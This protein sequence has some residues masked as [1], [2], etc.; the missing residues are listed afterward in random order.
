MRITAERRGD[1]AYIASEALVRHFRDDGVGSRFFAN[2][3]DH[4]GLHSLLGHLGCLGRLGYPAV[5]LTAGI[6]RL[7]G[8][9]ME[10]KGVCLPEVYPLLVGFPLSVSPNALHSST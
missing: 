8:S 3:P 5:M 7:D 4:G 2:R 9:A 10:V 6:P 1:T